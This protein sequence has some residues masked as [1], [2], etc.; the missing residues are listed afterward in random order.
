[1]VISP[2]L[3]IYMMRARGSKKGFS[4]FMLTGFVLLIIGFWGWMF[5]SD[6]YFLQPFFIMVAAGNL[7]MAIAGIKVYQNLPAYAPPVEVEQAALSA[8]V[9]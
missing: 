8:A 6:G 7:G 2:L 9:A 5:L 3:N 1:V 4:P